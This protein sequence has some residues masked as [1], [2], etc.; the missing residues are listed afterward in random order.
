[1]SEESEDW[2]RSD[3]AEY[4]ER[5]GPI[6]TM[7]TC[8]T[9]HGTGRIIYKDSDGRMKDITCSGCGGSGQR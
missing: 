5:R 3:L 1:M 4:I 2:V 9:C 7:G 6:I 8:G